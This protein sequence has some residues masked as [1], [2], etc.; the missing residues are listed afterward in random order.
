MTAGDGC[1]KTDNSI[2]SEHSKRRSFGPQVFRFKTEDAKCVC[3]CVCVA[4]GGG[5]GY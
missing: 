2:A 5:G 3:V 4:W 1:Q